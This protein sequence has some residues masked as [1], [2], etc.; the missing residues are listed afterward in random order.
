[1]KGYISYFRTVIL[2]NLQYK[3]AA[4]AGLTTQFFWG[5]LQIFIYEAFYAGRTDG[6][7]MEF[8]NLVTYVWLQQALFAL[9]YVRHR[10]SE[11]ADSIKNGSVAYELLRPYNMYTWWYIKCIAKKLAAVSLRCLPVIICACL[12]PKPYGISAP[13]SITTFLMFVIVLALGTIVL[14]GIIM[15]TQMIAFFTYDD[16]GINAI[17]FTIAE[18]LSGL[19][20]PLPLLP[21]ILQKIS[22]FL[23]FRLIGDL[24]FRI[25][26][27]DI[28]LSQVGE[29]ILMQ[30]IWIAVLIVAGNLIL[31]KAT[32][33][34]YIQGG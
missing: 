30:I 31:R 18:L 26:S 22:Y 6:V 23:P 19:T 3:A 27:G 13:L 1:M 32:K 29:N 16:K 20:L 17:I 11:F 5:F 15:L 21:Q 34:V 10:D 14:V 12:L 8:G 25:Y 28:P 4:I 7:P 9:I 24:S 2:S 33:K